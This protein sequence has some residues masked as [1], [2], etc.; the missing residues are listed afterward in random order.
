MPTP[1]LFTSPD[2][3]SVGLGWRPG[4]ASL[5]QHKIIGLKFKKIEDNFKK[6]ERKK[7]KKES[8]V[9]LMFSLSCQPLILELVGNEYADLTSEL[10]NRSVYFNKFL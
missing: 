4:N 8:L 2:S 3:D 7:K 1:P 10:L 6:R 5:D 9:I